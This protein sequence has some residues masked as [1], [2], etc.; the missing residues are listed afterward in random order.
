MSEQRKLNTELTEEVI[1]IN[2]KKSW[3]R[4]A[5]GVIG[6]IIFVLGGYV[7][8]HQYFSSEA[9]YRQEVEK[10]ALA[11]PAKLEAYKKAME[12]DVYGGKTPEETLQLFIDALKK[13]DIELASKYYILDSDSAKIDPTHLDSLRKADEEGRLPEIID[14]LSMAKR[15]QGSKGASDNDIWFVVTNDNGQVI[16]DPLLRFNKH[17]GIWKIERL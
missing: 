11:L 10:S 4:Y 17:S 12:A 2:P 6:V 14:L 7:A 5:V 16:A 3:W 8:W 13:G 1:E 15:D 9:R